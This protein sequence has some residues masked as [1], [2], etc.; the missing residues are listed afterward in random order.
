LVERG[1]GERAGYPDEAYADHGATLA[2]AAETAGADVVVRVRG[3]GAG[4]EAPVR[5]EQVAIGIVEPLSDAATVRDAADRGLTAF[6]LDLIPRITRAQAMDVLSSQATVVGYKAVLLAA[7]R[8]PRL[9]PMLTTAAGTVPPAQV[10]VLGAGVAGLQAIATARRLGAVVQ[11]YDVRPAAQE[12]IESLGARALLLPL[13]PGDAEDES[14]YAK[15]LGEAFFRRQQELL[16]EAVAGVDAVIC[17][18]Q[19]PGRPAPLLVTAAA[20][21]GMRPG[22]VIVDVAADRGGNCELTRPDEEHVT[23]G[24]VAILGP[25]DLASS[26]PHDASAMLSRNVTAFL[27]HLIDDGRLAIDEED[28][29]VHGT[30]VTRAGRIVHER[31]RQEM[32]A[33]RV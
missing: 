16:A 24:G 14:G 28:E 8:V 20:V 15:E 21:D 9:F 31:V 26:I 5:P 18:A 13:S 33:Q 7:V 3:W 1:A 11:A 30:L 23:P 2:D 25:T 6:A 32:E 22:S 4:T 17:T 19:I 12:D 27:L 29:I 10:L